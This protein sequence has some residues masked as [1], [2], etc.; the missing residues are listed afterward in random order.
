[1]E[2][3]RRPPWILV[4]ICA[5]AIGA[6]ALNEVRSIWPRLEMGASLVV[7]DALRHARQDPR[8]TA[9]L[10]TPVR[11]RWLV[12]GYIST[13][14]TG[15]SESRAW[16]PIY[17]TKSDGTIYARAGRASG[18][19]VFTTLEF[20][21]KQGP[22][23]DLME[24]P[25]AE[26]GPPRGPVYV[27]P[28]G[29][30]QSVSLDDLPGYYR[31]VLGLDVFLLPPMP[32]A[33]EAYDHQRH[34]YAA[35]PLIGSIRERLPEVARGADATVVAVLDDD[36]FANALSARYLL[37]FRGDGHVAVVA[38]KRLAPPAWRFWSRGRVLNARMRKMITKNIG[39]VAYGLPLSSDPT[40]VL[41]GGVDAPEDVDLM[42]ERFDGL[43]NVA[44]LRGDPGTHRAAPVDAEIVR[45]TDMA[46]TSGR[47]PCFVVH[48]GLSWDGRQ[49]IDARITE[50]LPGLR[51]DRTYD[52]VEIDLRAG[53]LM[54]R[55]TDV[56][57]PDVIPLA[58]T[59][60]YRLW[61]GESRAFGVG[62][63]HPYDILPVGSR[64]PYT[65]VD[66]I[67][68]DG[69]AIH[70]DRIS[71]GTGYAD[72]VYEH[73]NTA[74]AFLRSEFRWN[75]TGWDLRFTDGSVMRF[76]ENY[77]GTQPH[78]GAP[79]EMR[80]GTGHAIQFA[81]DGDRNL[82]KLTSPAGHAISFE[83]DARSRVA[84]AATDTAQ[85]VRYAYDAG[86]RLTA[87]TAGDRVTRFGYDDLNLTSADV[88]GKRV[89][90][91]TYK[92]GRVASLTPADGRTYTFNYLTLGTNPNLVTETIVY[93]PD[94]S[95]TR[96]RLPRD[97]N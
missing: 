88:S 29:D 74:T 77:G 93:A 56:F 97:R 36:L 30:L 26:L 23:I 47:Y 57:V 24:A 89:L 3:R 6:V 19:W 75:G 31:K 92:E 18:A 69:A 53:M 52:E 40:S 79:T 61:D 11:V 28:I 2:P 90:T 58:L 81:R 80:D 12:P 5:V 43:G 38:L 25:S 7:V 32:P 34:Q 22:T 45:R 49:A 59:R 65:Y 15:W 10:G 86:G 17:G 78:H 72:A 51:N 35:E 71:K 67:M 14:E 37:A 63:N 48:P 13:D 68:P 91:V 84:M 87:V 66:L 83:H 42:R 62:W 44:E 55:Q 94:G 46:S 9:A 76:P 50:C 21:P 54:T 70:Y 95:R 1:M 85:V 16:I 82:D 64:N 20:R 60:C 39:I 33:R 8:V 27:V 4:V 41:Y 73:T 96:I